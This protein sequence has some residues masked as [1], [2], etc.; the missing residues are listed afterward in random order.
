[1]KKI[2]FLLLF[3]LILFFP[4]TASSAD[5]FVTDVDVQY[6]VLDSGIT[7]VIHKISIEN[8]F[9]N[10]YATSYNLTLENINPTNIKAIYKGNEIEAITKVRDKNIDISINFDDAI[11]GK[12]KIRTFEIIYENSKFAQRTGEVWE[13][14]IP[15]LSSN[16]NFKSYN[17][18]LSIPET[19]GLE[20]Y[21][22]PKPTTTLRESGKFI[23]KFNK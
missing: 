8:L 1:M 18:S 9:T 12:G 2:L 5:E 4:K 22:S 17:L 23:Y 13:I 21:I 15:K 10:L 7:K 6:Q 16:S 20:A 19:F 14:S 11:V 3:L